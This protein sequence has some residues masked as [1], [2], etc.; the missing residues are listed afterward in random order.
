MEDY[1]ES[2]FRLE[3]AHGAARPK[4]ISKD[5]NVH[6]TS[7]TSAI[8]SLKDSGLVKHEPYEYIHLTSEGEELARSIS[9]KHSILRN[10]LIRILNVPPSIAEEDACS[11]EHYIHEETLDQLVKLVECIE[12]NPEFSKSFFEHFKSVQSKSASQSNSSPVFGDALMNNEPKVYKTLDELKPGEYGIIA[13]LEMHEQIR[14]RIMD[15][16]VIPGSKIGVVKL[17]PLGDPI[18]VDVRGFHLSIR[19][20]DAHGILIKEIGE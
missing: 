12:S 18:E 2:I 7:V 14:H 20:A 9:T 4:E 1:L 6:K 17:A 11:M 15:M 16:G 3:Q 19:K 5:L 10:F 13:R 8:K